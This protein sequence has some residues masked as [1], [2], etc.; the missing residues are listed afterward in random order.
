MFR[1]VGKVSPCEKN[2]S[3]KGLQFSRHEVKTRAGSLVDTIPSLG[4][5]FTNRDKLSQL[6]KTEKV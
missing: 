6:W 3:N 2:E 1:S 4:L 5:F